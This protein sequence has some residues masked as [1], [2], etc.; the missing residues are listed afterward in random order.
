MP[1]QADQLDLRDCGRINVDSVAAPVRWILIYSESLRSR[2]AAGS[3]AGKSVW[4]EPIEAH[5]LFGD[6]VDEAVVNL[7]RDPHHEPPG[8]ASFRQRLDSFLASV[9]AFT[10]MTDSFTMPGQGP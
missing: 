10:E 7:G 9:A 1:R 6:F 3:G 2:R 8:V 4:Y 5:V